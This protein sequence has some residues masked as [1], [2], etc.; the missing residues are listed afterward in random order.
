[1][2]IILYNDQ[3]DVQSNLQQLKQNIYQLTDMKLSVIWT[4]LDSKD[5][6]RTIL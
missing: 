1:M 5:P 2:Y 4:A 6:N 3:I